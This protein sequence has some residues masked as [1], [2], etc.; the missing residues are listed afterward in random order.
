MAFISR[1]QNTLQT[2]NLILNDIPH[3]EAEKESPLVS[4]WLITGLVGLST[5]LGLISLTM[6][7]L[8]IVKIRS[9]KRQLK[10]FEPVEFG[11]IASNLNRIAGPTA[12]IFSV[13]G[14]NP[15]FQKQTN[16]TIVPRGVYDN[17][18]RY[19]K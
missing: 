10:A 16:E 4:N 1:L 5:A 2:Y 14:S 18:L 6:V 12:N 17:E 13:Q 7:I 8:Y 9:L 3:L 19:Y 15:I 11:S